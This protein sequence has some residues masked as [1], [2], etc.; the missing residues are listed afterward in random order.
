MAMARSKLPFWVVLNGVLS[1][2]ILVAAWLVLSARPK[3]PDLKNEPVSYW[4]N[5]PDPCV[6]DTAKAIVASGRPYPNE[7]RDEKGKLLQKD[8]W[9]GDQLFVLPGWFPL[10]NESPAK[11]YPLA[12][13]SVVSTAY[14]LLKTP[15]AQQRAP[16]TLYGN[17]RCYSGHPPAEWKENYYPDAQ[18]RGELIDKLLKSLEQHNAGRPVKITRNE[19]SDIR[20]TELLIDDREH[21]RRSADYIPWDKDLAQEIDGRRRLQAITCSKPYDPETEIG[22]ADRCLV[23]FYVGPGRW[24]EFSLYQQNLPLVQP[25]FELLLTTLNASRR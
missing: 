1:C 6:R 20:M 2:C 16:S 5:D 12:Y 9:I 15:Q 25:L 8:A 24:L 23:W 14:D 10:F 11:A 22:T 4:L 13:T 21:L 18:T 7:V 17:V 19:R 3:P